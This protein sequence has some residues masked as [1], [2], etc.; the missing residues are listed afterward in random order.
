MDWRLG[1]IDLFVSKARR[2]SIII[3]PNTFIEEGKKMPWLGPHPL[4]A[5]TQRIGGKTLSR[6]T[7]MIGLLASRFLDTSQ[8]EFQEASL[9]R[10]TMLTVH[11]KKPGCLS[12]FLLPFAGRETR[13]RSGSRHG[14]GPAIMEDIIVILCGGL[15]KLKRG[16]LATFLFWRIT[17]HDIA[18]DAG[19]RPL[20]SN[21][22]LEDISC[23]AVISRCYGAL[24]NLCLLLL[25]RLV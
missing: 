6:M 17:R 24:L 1:H 21:H 12:L 4:C 19:Q 22:K 18:S 13:T 5:N 23:P 20:G 10:S 25:L 14:T 7:R 15:R 9:K 16:P 8:Q 11:T 2:C 3:T